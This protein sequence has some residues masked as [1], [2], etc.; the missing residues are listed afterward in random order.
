MDPNPQFPLRKRVT[1]LTERFQLRFAQQ[2]AVLLDG[3]AGICVQ[4]SASGLV[5]MAVAERD[6]DAAITMIQIAFPALRC[7]PVEVLLLDDGTMEPYVRVRVTTP[8]EHY[9][10]VVGQLRDRHASI[11]SAD[12]MDRR[13][14]T[15][16]AIAPLSQLLGLDAVLASATKNRATADYAFVDYRP[17]SREP[18]PPRNPAAKA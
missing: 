18:G 13:S 15:V 12:N 16:T 8:E 3:F 1:D 17:M 7:G 11:E 6:L 5:L 10:D 14:K 9:R 2:A 4:Q